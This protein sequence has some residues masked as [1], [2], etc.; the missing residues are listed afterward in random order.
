MYGSKSRRQTSVTLIALAH[1]IP[2]IRAISEQPF[3]LLSFRFRLKVPV[4]VEIVFSVVW[5]TTD[6]IGELVL[7]RGVE[8]DAET[9][10]VLCVSSHGMKPTK[11]E[12]V[13]SEHP[14]VITFTGL[15]HVEQ[16]PAAP[17]RPFDAA[18]CG[19]MNV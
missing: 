7:Y 6:N 17:Y 4:A 11:F 1:T 16:E 9:V 12:H 10:R 14:P 15:P 5:I 19:T 18:A 3:R 8:A 13:E 2:I